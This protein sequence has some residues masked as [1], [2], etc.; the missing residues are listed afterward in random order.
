MTSAAVDV[1]RLDILGAVEVRGLL[2]ALGF[3]PG[4]RRLAELSPPQKSRQL[5]KRR[6]PR[7]GVEG[8]L[9]NVGFQPEARQTRLIVEWLEPACLAIF[10]VL[11]CVMALG[12][13][14][15]VLMTTPSNWSSVILRGVLRRGPSNSLSRRFSMKRRQRCGNSRV[16]ILPGWIPRNL[17]PGVLPGG[18]EGR[19]R[20]DQPTERVLDDDIAN[21]VEAEIEASLVNER[22]VEAAQ[23]HQS[24]EWVGRPRQ[25][26]DPGRLQVRLCGSPG[27]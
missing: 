16:R 26:K 3:D 25:A 1:A 5:N 9:D 8:L 6:R 18:S 4:E 15:G 14:P 22:V 10:R 20:G 17:C 21:L 7:R 23:Q 12:I 24:T 13:D 2:H 11:P 19:G 27:G